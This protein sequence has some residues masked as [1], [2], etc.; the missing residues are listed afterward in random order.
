MKILEEIVN[1]LMQDLNARE[2]NSRLE[3]INAKKTR[4][5]LSSTDLFKVSRS[6]TK[7][8]MSK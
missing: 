2:K 3:M 4:Q 8:R 1:R 5:L 6:R 7:I